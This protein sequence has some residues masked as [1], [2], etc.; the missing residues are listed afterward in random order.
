MNLLPLLS[1]AIPAHDRPNELKFGL[2]RFISQIAGKYEKEIEIIVSDDHS[3]NDSLQ[4]I[5]SF[6]DRY[7]FI[8]YRRFPRNIGLERNLIECAKGCSGEFLWLFGDDDYLETDDAV[9]QIMKLLQDGCYDFYIFNR[10]RRSFDLSETLTDNWMKIDAKKSF[11]F[12]GLRKFCKTYG[13]ISI[14]GFISVNIFRRDLFQ[15][16]EAEK[17][18]GTMYPQLGAMVEAFYNRPTLLL[19]RPLICHRTQTAEEKKI[20]LGLK[21]IESDFMSDEQRR[22][23]I[24]FSH[25]YVAMIDK[26]IKLGAFTPADILEIP[27]NTVINGLLI[28]FL[29][30]TVTQNH[31]LFPEMNSAIWERTA[32]FFRSL[33]LDKERRQR[34]EAVLSKRV[35]PPVVTRPRVVL[36]DF[37]EKPAISVITPSYNQADF[38]GECLASVRDQTYKPIEHLVYDPGS[39]DDSRAIASSH[40]HVTLFAEPDEGQSDAVNKG[41]ERV[42]GD[43]IAWL[44]SDDCFANSHVFARVVQRFL[45]PDSPDI[46]YGKGIYINESGKKLRDVYIN[47]DPSTLNWRFQQE[48]GILQP[49]LFM[50][51]K[52]IEKIGPLRNDLHY[53]M[54]YE[55]WIRCMKAGLKFAY[56]DECF[57]LARYHINNK[58]YGMRGNSYHEVCKIMKEHFG[59]VNHMWLKRYA[60]FLA[61]GL[62]GVLA[63]T[64][65]THVADQQ[66]ILTN[67]RQLLIDYNSDMETY[68]LLLECANQNSYSAT[69]REMQRLHIVP[70]VPCKIIQNDQ[71]AT[72]S[73]C[74]C[75]FLS[76]QLGFLRDMKAYYDETD[77]IAHLFSTL[78]QGT[79]MIDVGAHH[80]SALM[81]FLNQGWKIFAFE[82]DNKNRG[83][84]LERLSNH[85]YAP[86]VQVDLRA[87]S[88]NSSCGLNFYCSDESTGISSLSA[89]HDTHKCDQRVDVTTLSEFLADKDIAQVD[90]LK[91]DTEGHDFF[92][93]QGF[94]W[95]RFKP[96]VIECEFED[97]KTV[98]LDYTFHDMAEFLTDKGYQ[99]Y[100]SEWHPIVRYG[101]R[102]NW[103]CLMRYPCKLTNEKAWGNLLAFRDSID[104]DVVVDAVKK[105]LKFYGPDGSVTKAPPKPQANAS[106]VQAICFPVK[107]A[108]APFAEIPMASVQW[109]KGNGV[110]VIGNGSSL[111]NM[112]FQ[113]L[114]AFKSIGMNAA[115]RHWKTKGIYPNYY[116]CLDTVVIESLKDEIYELIQKRV[117]NGIQLFF[118]RKK[119]LNFYPELN[120]V[121]EVTFF[122]DYFNSPYFEGITQGITTGS[123]A[124]LLGAM[125]GYKRIY[126]LGIDLNY[127]QQIPEAKSVKGHIL[128][129]TETPAKNPNYFFDDYQRKGDR[130]NVPDS[131]PDLHYQSWGMVKE[132]LERFGVHVLNCNPNSRLDIFDYADIN[133]ML[134][135]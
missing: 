64:N 91:I 109:K 59:Y 43:I 62:D 68:S 133:E 112:E 26:L 130:F 29:I 44:N 66:K 119:L 81:P 15:Q 132:R 3:P 25:P 54:D 106:S 95:E 115:Y 74:K 128:E 13:F 97:T 110:L 9:D 58:T 84:L 103:K 120:N 46:V 51:R 23:A 105:E 104:D 96:A 6:A 61:E 122:E 93:L 53:S 116:I 4:E 55:Y 50:K 32:I 117:K 40:P 7:S 114:Q 94:P 21:S 80:G 87:V 123:F 33:P 108:Y 82:P 76:S 63:H 49:A 45:E 67:Y 37:K 17:Y 41:F 10:T 99:V 121:P 28:D 100:V 31:Q 38:L 69:L 125:L 47:K 52:V 2:E 14:I 34:I 134:P 85:K 56:V 5:R 126:L 27:E 107:T 72:V 111:R 131:T 90:F 42:R 127:V 18:F 65:N 124:A 78:L 75:N 36:T 35:P 86:N 89:F 102:H 88:N 1:I 71:E 30:Q 11:E 98:P 77:C 101:I 48:D 79:V 22:N 39:E 60:E 118:L 129:M 20:A 8:K 19:G 24:Y 70:L 113:R 83:K 12:S 135:R 92:V 16:V 57:A 73:G